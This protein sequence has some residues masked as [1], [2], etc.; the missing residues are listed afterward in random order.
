M[1]EEAKAGLGKDQDGY[2]IKHL[3][4]LSRYGKLVK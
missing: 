4:L 2:R 1:Y 3:M